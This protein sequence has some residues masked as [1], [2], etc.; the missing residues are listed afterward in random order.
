[1][2]RAQRAEDE[3]RVMSDQLSKAVEDWA[4]AE[5]DLRAEQ[6]RASDLSKELTTL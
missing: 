6:E 4:S 1:M 3:W 2:D 5:E